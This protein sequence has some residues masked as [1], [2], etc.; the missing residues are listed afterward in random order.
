MKRYDRYMVIQL[1]TFVKVLGRLN[2]R[3]ISTAYYHVQVTTL[4]LV[5]IQIL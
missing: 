5:G 1:N 2:K 4:V 3:S